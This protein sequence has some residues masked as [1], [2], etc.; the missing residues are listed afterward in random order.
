MNWKTFYLFKSCL[1]FSQVFCS[2]WHTCPTH[3]FL[4]LYLNVPLSGATANDGSFLCY[5]K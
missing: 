1:I 2:F 4:D 3:N 5:A